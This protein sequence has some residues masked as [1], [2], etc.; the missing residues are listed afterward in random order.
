MLRAYKARTID[1]LGA[2]DAEIIRAV[3]ILMRAKVVAHLEGLRF[4]LLE[5]RR[6]DVAVLLSLRS[7]SESLKEETGITAAALLLLRVRYEAEAQAILEVSSA[8]VQRALLGA[9]M[10]VQQ[11]G[12]PV[13]D[14]VRALRGTL[15]AQG[16]TPASSSTFGTIFRT[17]IMKAYHVASWQFDQRPEVA[18]KLWGYRYLTMRDERVRPAHRILEGVTLEKDHPRWNTIY[19][20]NGYN[21]R[22]TVERLF[23]EPESGVSFPEGLFEPIQDTV[24][25]IDPGF[26][27]NFGKLFSPSGIG[28]LR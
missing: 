14:G 1:P 18:N 21:C 3:P 24:P 11:A 22:C 27:T 19:P 12:L 28:D 10:E 16:V 15:A 25:G 5:A 9:M 6:A 17:E 20:P 7:E 23:R 8:R 26:A 2:F 4:A 13:R